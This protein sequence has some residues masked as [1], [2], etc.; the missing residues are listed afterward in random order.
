MRVENLRG[1]TDECGLV[2]A[3]QFLAQLARKLEPTHARQAVQ[4]ARLDSTD[5]RLEASYRR[6]SASRNNTFADTHGLM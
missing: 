3:G 5:R 4:R 1:P 2:P 6:A